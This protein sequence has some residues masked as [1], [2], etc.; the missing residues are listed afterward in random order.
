MARLLQAIEAHKA[1][2]ED[3]GMELKQV[4]VNALVRIGQGDIEE[5]SVV[6]LR[7]DSRGLS[8]EI[9]LTVYVCR[10]D[11]SD[12]DVIPALSP[13]H[14]DLTDCSIGKETIFLNGDIVVPEISDIP[15]E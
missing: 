14:I 15:V 12:D 6:I 8:F 2:I 13:N 3:S 1:R 7:G 4:I 10:E 11:F 5:A 9:A